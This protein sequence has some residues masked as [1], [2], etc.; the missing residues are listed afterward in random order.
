MA[1][2]DARHP[3]ITKAYHDYVVLRLDKISLRHIIPYKV[4]YGYFT[5]LLVCAHLSVKL[6]GVLFSFL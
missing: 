5:F 2:T 6:K 3:T 4:K 1:L